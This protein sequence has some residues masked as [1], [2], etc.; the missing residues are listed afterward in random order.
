[1]SF[2]KLNQVALNTPFGGRRNLSKQSETLF[3]IDELEFHTK[4][5]GYARAPQALDVTSE[6][7]NGCLNHAAYQQSAD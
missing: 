1:M 6:T 5:R 2:H 3:S 7:A 4:Q